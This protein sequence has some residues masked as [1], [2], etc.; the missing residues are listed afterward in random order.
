MTP[1]AIEERALMRRLEEV[2]R[3]VAQW[4]S[5]HNADANELARI[6]AD[7][8]RARSPKPDSPTPRDRPEWVMCAVL[9]M[10]DS[11]ETWCERT[12]PTSERV[13]QDA[14]HALLTERSEGRY[15]LCQNC[16]RAIRDLLTHPR[17]YG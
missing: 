5:G 13:F 14:T 10:K 12:A 7:L 4:E 11:R 2:A 15:V 1:M 6:L 16:S 17:H 8:D 3:R 9:G